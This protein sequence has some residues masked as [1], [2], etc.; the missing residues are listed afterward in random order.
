MPGLHPNPRVPRG[1]QVFS[2]NLSPIMEAFVGIVQ[3]SP[4]LTQN[5]TRGF[6]L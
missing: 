5:E 3:F 4:Q 2:V 6:P 1:K